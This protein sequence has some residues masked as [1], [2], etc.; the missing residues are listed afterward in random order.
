M[1]QAK[2]KTATIYYLIQMI[3]ADL[4]IIQAKRNTGAKQ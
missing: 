2:K 3:K 1:A 4:L